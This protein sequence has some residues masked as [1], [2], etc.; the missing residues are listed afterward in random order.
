M[1]TRADDVCQ[2]EAFHLA[3]LLPPMVVL[4]QGGFDPV[5]DLVHLGGYFRAN[6]AYQLFRLFQLAGDIHEFLPGLRGNV[7][8]LL[9]APGFHLGELLTKKNNVFDLAFIGIG[10]G[11]FSVSG[12]PLLF[13]LAYAA[14][15][16]GNQMAHTFSS[17]RICFAL[18]R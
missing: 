15:E 2:E 9:P 10:H 14:C 5:P 11:G 7:S 3:H 1:V 13:I 12:F 18:G 16:R 4:L 17:C 8:V 6:L